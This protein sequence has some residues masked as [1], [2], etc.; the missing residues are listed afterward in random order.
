MA[1]KALD[2]VLKDLRQAAA[3]GVEQPAL[4]VEKLIKEALKRL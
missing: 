2:E 4:S 1:E 3:G